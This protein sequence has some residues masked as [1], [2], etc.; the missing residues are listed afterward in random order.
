MAKILVVDD[1]VGIRELLSEILSDEGHTVVLAENA[2]RARE[3]RARARPDLVLLDIWMPDVDGITLLKE[4]AAGGQL[5][6]PVIIMS[7]HATIET[8]VEATRIGALDFLE[9]P[10]A[11]QK[12]LATVKRALRGHDSRAMASLALA[13]FGRSQ[14]MSD[15]KKRLAQLAASSSALLLR[16]EPGSMPELYARYLQA[17]GSPGLSAAEVLA[18]SSTDALAEAAGGVLFV[19]ELEALSRNQQKHLAFLAPRAERGKVRIVSFTARDTRTLVEAHG[20]E[21]QLLARLSALIIGV[22]PVRDYAQD[23]PD[24]AN[25]MLLQLVET[26]VCPP[27]R[28]ATAALNL[29]RNHGWP[30][31]LEELRAATRNLALSS[32]EEE[33][34][35]AD[36][37]RVLRDSQPARP[38][39]L[40]VPL[41]R[42]LREAREA[43]ER[44]YFEHHLAQ[45]SGSIARVAERSGLERTHLYRKLKQLGLPAGRREDAV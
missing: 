26:R 29:L 37:E 40:G 31:N 8:A 17:P 18:A 11:L 2:T 42:P 21:P 43:F 39:G 34:G 32:L 22:P 12:L 36:V 41:D 9:K 14:V 13:H 45:E 4:W 23:V 38:A 10:I 24:I 25:L 6:M 35:A 16:G 19:E 27:R 7:G 28:F 20:F 3:L 15:F 1:E 33:I 5:T 30:G 44:A